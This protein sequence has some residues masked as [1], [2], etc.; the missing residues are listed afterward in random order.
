MQSQVIDFSTERYVPMENPVMRFPIIL[1]HGSTDCGPA[2][3]AMVAAHY[4][5]RIPIAR[6]REY[7]GTDTKGTTLGG[8]RIAAE[9]LGFKAQAVR[10]TPE[11]LASMAL[12]TIGHW[13]EEGRNHFVVIYQMNAKHVW[14]A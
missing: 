5:K 14:V 13:R 6:L 2:A 4:G 9:R 1:Q 11:T 3:L 10:I 8:L 7:A 12:P